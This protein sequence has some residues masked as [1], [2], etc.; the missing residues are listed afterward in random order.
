MCLIF[1]EESLWSLIFFPNLIPKFFFYWYY[2]IFQGIIEV[3]LG[4]KMLLIDKGTYLLLLCR[5]IQQEN[6]RDWALPHL[7]L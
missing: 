4:F 2:V 1:I 6:N 7:S 3:M 5:T